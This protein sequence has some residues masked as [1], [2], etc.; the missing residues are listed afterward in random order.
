MAL[1]PKR[2][3]LCDV[4]GSKYEHHALAKANHITGL[5]G[6]GASSHCLPVDERLTAQV[7]QVVI[8]VGG[9]D[10]GML[11]DDMRV[12]ETNIAIRVTTDQAGQSVQ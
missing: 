8:V 12:F 1:P 11:S 2:D 6:G 5:Q 9:V 7:H 4:L 10:L 3:A